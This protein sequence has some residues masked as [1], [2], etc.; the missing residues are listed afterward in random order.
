MLRFIHCADV[1][2]G[3]SIKTH[4]DMPE[5][6]SLSIQ[7][8]TYTSF[9]E[10][11]TIALEKNVD[12]VLI[13]GDVYDQEQ[14]FIR[15][16]WF[17]K[18]QGERL[19]EYNIPLFIIH[20]NHDPLIKDKPENVDNVYVFPTEIEAIKITNNDGDNIFIHGFSYPQKGF[21]DNP[22]PLFV[23]KGSEE[24]YHIALLHGQETTQ[25]EHEPYAPFTVKELE[26]RNFDYWA[27]GHIHKRSI[28][29]TSP[30]IVYSG[31]IQGG[32]RNELGEKGCYYVELS[33]STANLTF[34][35]TASVIWESFCFSIDSLH[36]MEDLLELVEEGLQDLHSNTIY[37]V[38]IELHGYGILHDKLIEEQQDFLYT[39]RNEV[40]APYIWVDRVELHTSPIYDR[41]KLKEQDHLLG[42]VIRVVDDRKVNRSEIDSVFKPI[43]SHAT[44]KK[45]VD[46]LTNDEIHDLLD[47]AE[48]KLLSPLLSEVKKQ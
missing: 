33:K 14:R 43:F 8:A 28:L 41:N 7:Q 47:Q 34:I 20:G 16:Q 30:P 9:E 44:V 24:D 32:H 36:K 11:I 2:L 31:S 38:T 45:Y 18:K 26:E 35:N 1:H 5:H 10:I 22:A 3:R 48:K 13:S 4:T 6:M 40:V 37:L 25:S 23:R 21:Y 39:L 15:G 27:L 17:L 29:N 12:F 19:R 42:D 46:Q